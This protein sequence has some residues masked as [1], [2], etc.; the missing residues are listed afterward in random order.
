MESEVLERIQNMTLTTDEDEVMPIRPVKREKVLEEFSLSLI[1]KFLT[2]KKINIRTAKNLLRSMWKLGDDLKIIEVGEGL[3]QFK[4]SMESQLM[5]VWNNGPWCFDNHLL[6][7]R[8]WEKGMSV[9]N[10]TFTKQPFWIQVWGL[11]FDLINEKAGSDIGQSLGKL[12][13]VDS[14]AFTTE[15][16]RFLRIR[17]EVPLHKP[18]RH[19]GPVISPEGEETRVAFRYER[20]VGWCFNCG[21]IGHEQ[22]DCLVPVSAENAE[23]PYGEWLKAGYRTSST[24]SRKEQPQQRRTQR[25][26]TV[27]PPTSET[28]LSIEPDTEK[29]PSQPEMNESPKFTVHDHS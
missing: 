5:W 7:L 27:P 19:G 6:A 15:Q 2:T 21:R 3:I 23:R 28:D 8:R 1:G 16:S 17:V 22:G 13:E 11:P 20:L 18:L 26:T 12:V 4:F 14:K 9:R 10:V 25:A 24:E 29:S